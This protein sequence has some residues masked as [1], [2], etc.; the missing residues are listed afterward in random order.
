MSRTMN[1]VDV[2][3][4]LNRLWAIHR[5]SLPVYLGYAAPWARAGND[6]VRDALTVIGADHRHMAERLEELIVESGG[7]VGGVEFPFRFTAWHDLSLDYLRHRLVQDQQQR[8][9]EIERCVAQ[10]PSSPRAAAIAQEALGEAKGHFEMLR[11]LAT[12]RAAAGG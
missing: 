10:L 5:C 12:Q 11:E 7:V 6:P 8:I 3:P 9:A 1:S 2:N 4:I